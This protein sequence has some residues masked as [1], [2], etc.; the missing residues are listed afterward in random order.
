MK[1]TFS[2]PVVFIIIANVFLNSNSSYS[3][4]FWNQA[5]SFNGTD[6]SHISVQDNASLDLTGSFTVECWINPLN[7]VFPNAQTILAKRTLANVNSGYAMFLL[8]GKIL[9]NTG[10]G[11][12]ITGRTVIPNN[13]WTHVAGKYNSATNTFSLYINGLPDTSVVISA[14]PTLNNDSILIGYGRGLGSPFTGLLD[15]IRIWNRALPGAE[16]SQNFRTSLGLNSGIYSGLVLALTFQK[17]ESSGTTFSVNDYSGAG[18]NCFNR[19]V[20]ALNLTNKLYETVTFNE[21]GEFDGINDYLSAPNNS[22][23][24][25]LNEITLEA[26]IYPRSNSNSIIIQKGTPDGVVTN[27]RLAILNKTFVA[28]RNQ[29]FSFTTTDTIVPNKWTHIAFTYEA[30]SGKYRFYLN[31]KIIK[32]TIYNAGNIISTADSLYIGGTIGMNDF[33][34]FIDEVRITEKVKTQNEILQNLFRSVDKSNESAFDDVS[35]NLDGSNFSNTGAGPKL[36]FRNN[37]RFSSPATIANQPVSPLIRRDNK[38]FTDAFYLSAADLRIPISG[39]AGLTEDVI[40][41]YENEPITKVEVFVALNHQNLSNLKLV[42]NAPNGD[43]T[44]LFDNTSTAG[45][46][47][48]IV[49]IF[50]DNAEIAY[51]NSFTSFAPSMQSLWSLNSTLTGNTKGT[52]NLTIF[53]QTGTDTGRIY[54]WGIRF[55]NKTVKPKILESSIFIQGF[56]NNVTNSTVRDT[57]FYNLR[58]SSFPYSIVESKRVFIPAN[59]FFNINFNNALLSTEYYIE[60][61]HR[62]SISVWSSATEKFSY[63]NGF[64]S[65]NFAGSASTAFADNLVSIDTSPVR[66]GLYSGDINQDGTIDAGDLSQVENDAANSLSGYVQSDV[67]GDD[68]VD[69]GDVSVVENNAALGVS[70]VTP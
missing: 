24:N 25:P 14:P 65:R 69:A 57:V 51:T 7:S 33:D 27:Y 38:Y 39:D 20:T 59:N 36:S 58:N 5:G 11:L 21:S 32:D 42:L 15:D 53:D 19:N 1:R 3:Q 43:Y 18:N 10:I 45:T 49:T 28:G 6:S 61:I 26:W 37:A 66:F 46:D 54:G 70:V 52:W 55:N 48:N 30:G 23:I 60:V 22:V 41:V 68:F 13:E 50:D 67:T 63:E 8:N 4:M 56:Y 47:N 40:E 16:I 2:I 9:F 12:G 17:Q 62:N 34:G 29:N 35:Y 31:G 64:T 44:F